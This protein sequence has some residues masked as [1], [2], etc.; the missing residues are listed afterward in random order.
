MAWTHP[1]ELSRYPTRE[2]MHDGAELAEVI[3]SGARQRPEQ[4]FGS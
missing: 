1:V 2:E 4:G 3:L